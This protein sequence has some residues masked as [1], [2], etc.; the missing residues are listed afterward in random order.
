MWH[1]SVSLGSVN[2]LRQTLVKLTFIVEVI[3]SL[4]S[5]NVIVLLMVLLHHSSNLDLWWWSLGEMFEVTDRGQPLTEACSAPQARLTP[6]NARRLYSFAKSFP[7]VCPTSW[8][9]STC[10][11]TGYWGRPPS[12]WSRAGETTHWCLHLTA[13]QAQR[14]MKHSNPGSVKVPPDLWGNF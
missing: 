14:N 1:G 9:R 3:N 7:S 8:R 5:S 10:C 11:R 4:N 6:V 13:K 2:S 12:S